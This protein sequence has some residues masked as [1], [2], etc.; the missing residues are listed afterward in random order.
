MHYRCSEYVDGGDELRIQGEG[1]TF[2]GG[3][4]PEGTAAP[5]MYGWLDVLLKHVCDITMTW[6]VR[7]IGGYINLLCRN[8]TCGH[9]KTNVSEEPDGLSIM[10]QWFLGLY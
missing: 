4:G 5:R 8:Q 7:C 10:P 2:E 1:G 6:K 9:T 3:L